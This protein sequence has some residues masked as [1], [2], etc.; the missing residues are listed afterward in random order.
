MHCANCNGQVVPRTSGLNGGGVA[1]LVLTILFCLPLCWLPFVIPGCKNKFC[2][3][4]GAP[5]S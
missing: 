5:M 3:Q 2:P 4:C 1:L